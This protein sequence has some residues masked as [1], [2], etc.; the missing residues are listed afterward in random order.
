[1]N[2]YCGAMEVLELIA[3]LSRTIILDLNELGLVIVFL[4]TGNFACLATPTHFM[5]YD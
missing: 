1:M 2:T 4:F 5:F 3:Y